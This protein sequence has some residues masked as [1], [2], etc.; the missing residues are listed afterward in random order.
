MREG[1]MPLPWNEEI[2][3]SLQHKIP[4]GRCCFCYSGSP[5]AAAP[6]RP[7]PRLRWPDLCQQHHRVA[8]VMYAC[9][10]QARARR[11]HAQ[12]TGGPPL[13]WPTR[14]GKC[15]TMWHDTL[16]WRSRSC[17]VFH[18]CAVRTVPCGHGDVHVHVRA[19]PPRAGC[20][21]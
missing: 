13:F 19:A 10:V 2:S 9:M 21:C 5:P 16:R 15:R 7:S 18:H 4:A 6:L 8:G 1:V 11:V 12:T 20:C 14:P 3:Q 17:G